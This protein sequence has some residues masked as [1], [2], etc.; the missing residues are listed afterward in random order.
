MGRVGCS[1][2]P[3]VSNAA[4]RCCHAVRHASSHHMNATLAAT[5]H[6]V[7]HSTKRRHARCHGGLSS[8]RQQHCHSQPHLSPLPCIAHG[9]LPYRYTPEAIGCRDRCSLSM[10]RL[11]CNAH[12]HAGALAAGV[13]HECRAAAKPRLHV[14]VATR[15]ADG[16]ATRSGGILKHTKSPS[17]RAPLV[18]SAR[19]TMSRTA[20]RMQGPKHEIFDGGVAD[21]CA[22]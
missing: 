19:G 4:T 15:H 6:A 5:A 10:L 8:E 13:E 1:E 11:S 2:R 14:H 20:I 16:P 9:D 22:D 21:D 3:A 12:A 7:A 18:P 17:R